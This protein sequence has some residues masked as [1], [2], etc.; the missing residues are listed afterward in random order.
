M[1]WGAL[2]GIAVSLVSAV[3]LT[4]CAVGPDFAPPPAPPVNGYT[5]DPLRI[6]S[7]A[8]AGGTAQ[9]FVT[10]LDLPGQWWTLFRS[11]ALNSLIEQALAA[12]P[13]LQAAQAALR[14]AKENVYAQQGALLPTVDG[15]FIGSRQ[16]YQISQPSDV[17]STPT[18]NLF[19]AQLNISYTPDVFGGTRR[20]I[21]SLEAQADSQRFALEATYLT[22]TSNLAGAAVQE[23]SLRGQIAATLSI[24][25]IETDVLNVMRRQ[26]DLGQIA[27]G[28]VVAQEAAL[29]QAEQTL[30]PL[31]KQLAQQRDLLAALTGG[32]PSERL[33]E[34]FVLASLRLPRDLPISL[35]S[36]L[37]EQRPDI[38]AAEANLQA[39]SAQIGVAIAN[40]LP[41]V[42]L[43]G[44]PG[45]TA[46]A[47][48][49]LFTPG[50][51]FWTAAGSITQPIFHAGTLLHR[52]L[53][54]RATYD[55]AE[56][57]YRSTVITAFQNVADVLRAI[58]SDAVALQKAVASESAAAKSLDITRRRRELGDI[59]YLG[60]LNA[61]QTY[62][63]AL[64]SLAQARAARY[65]D[66]V[67]LFQALGGGWW[68]RDDVE[69][70][71][72]LSIVNLFQ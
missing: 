24:V 3:L 56:A 21:E 11:K 62:Q 28:D 10:D 49:Q 66:T 38:R 71:R 2:R 18:Y 34:R 17:G 57:Q 14:V 4:R 13:D 61:Q 8:T 36:K 22:L 31:Q 20:S 54:A 51:G 63:Q 1:V 33:T 45:S 30:P 19:T 43:S 44:V 29:A 42:T 39:A 26:R 46:L 50:F 47:V 72:P 35:P 70:E 52:E 9:H 65:A 53:A 12:N 15:N 59:N 64:L 6:T 32:F 48:D 41:N 67:A 68:N 58:Q 23:A 40:R 55:Q 69:P 25:K 16:Q 37:V 27:E 5:P 60:L 7:A